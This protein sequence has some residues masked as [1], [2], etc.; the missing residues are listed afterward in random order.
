MRRAQVE[1]RDAPHYRREAFIEGLR[2]AGWDVQA[3]QI[4]KPTA[5]DVL[6]IWNRYGHWHDEALRFER[7]GARVVVAENG[8]LGRDWCEDIWYALALNW[9]NGHGTWNVG[10]PERARRLF[11]D[12]LAEWAPNP[13]GP[14][15]VLAQRGIGVPPVQSPPT[16]V[17]RVLHDCQ[18]HGVRVQLREHPGNVKADDLAQAL[19]SARACITWASGAGIKAI[20][21]GVPVYHGLPDWIGAPAARR[22]SAPLA[23]PFTGDRWP[24][25]TRLSWAMWNLREISRG[26]AFDHLL[27]RPA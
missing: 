2:N 20:L 1:V 8:Y 4:A 12:R 14:V 15:L 9:H 18:A 19:K 3:H 7:A 26:D 6:V 16:F 23:E 13:A 24:F 10:G 21:A 22:Y 5:D 25:L 11:L 17:A 27:R